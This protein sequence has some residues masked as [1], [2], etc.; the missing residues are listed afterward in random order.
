MKERARE[1]GTER[2]RTERVIK[3]ERGRERERERERE[4]E[5]ES[6]REA[7]WKPHVLSSGAARYVVT[8]MLAFAYAAFCREVLRGT[9]LRDCIGM[10]QVHIRYCCRIEMCALAVAQGLILF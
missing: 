10:R 9:L 4:S 3:R 5:R 7:D 8:L 6:E 2:E 1:P